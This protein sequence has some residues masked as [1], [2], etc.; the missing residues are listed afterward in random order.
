MAVIP[1]FLLLF[2]Q[3]E[4]LEE[5]I[6]GFLFILI[7]SDNLFD[8]MGFAKSFKNIYIVFLAFYVFARR[9]MFDLTANIYKYFL[10]FILFAVVGL[11]YSPVVETAVQ[12]T[13]SYF[14]LLWI[15][16]V[17]IVTGFRKGG[18]YFLR[19]LVFFILTIC[20]IGYFFRFVNPEVAFSHGGR[21]RGIFGN[22]NGMGIFLIMFTI[23]FEVVRKRFPGLFTRGDT[24]AIFAIILFFAYITGSRNTLIS[25]FL[26][27][28]FSYFF[29][30][31]TM[32]GF[33]MFLV[34]IVLT[35]YI[36]TNF[37]SIISSLGLGHEL[38]METLKEGS[39]RLIAWDFAWQ[40]IKRSIF[41]GRGMGYDEY[42]MRL[43]APILTDLGHEGGVHNS[44]LIIWMNTG[45]FGLVSFFA[46]FIALFVRASLRNKL[47][48]PAMIAVLF[49]INFEP[50]LAA[51]LNPYTILFFT[52]LTIL[53]HQAF[54]EHEQ[55]PEEHQDE[56]DQKNILA[57]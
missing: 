34:V 4:W 13:I 16:P 27:Y 15:V 53:T 3:K 18:P 26:F 31:S 24:L 39:G 29:R 50:W 51:S 47:A 11:F 19:N 30:L 42:Y 56:K 10:P 17:Y 54:Y 48:F 35:E 57:A 12:K 22:P 20:I 37:V 25:I 45:L 52:I 7:L 2:A 21:F 55:L 1:V 40:E 32:L 9:D 36:T 49:S 33:I 46:A 28:I 43:N 23:L 38:R 44:Y 6:I 14:I 41:I 5:L 8:A